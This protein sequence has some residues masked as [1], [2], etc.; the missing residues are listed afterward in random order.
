MN[1]SAAR[2][3]KLAAA[4][5][6]LRDYKKGPALNSSIGLRSDK[7]GSDDAL[8]QLTGSGA[9]SVRSTPRHSITPSSPSVPA[10][11]SSS[12]LHQDSNDFAQRIR[13]L[14]SDNQYLAQRCQ[15]LSEENKKLKAI[16]ET[17][18]PSTEIEEELELLKADIGRLQ[19]DL[20][21]LPGLRD[22][23][24]AMTAEREKLMTNLRQAQEDAGLET[25]RRQFSELEITKEA[26]ESELNELRQS[27]QQLDQI[28]PVHTSNH[29]ETAIELSQVKTERDD[30]ATRLQSLTADLEAKD[31]QV[32]DLRKH[33]EDVTTEFANAQKEVHELRQQ[34]ASK[35]SETQEVANLRSQLEQAQLELGNARKQQSVVMT[36]MRKVLDDMAGKIKVLTNER[37]AATTDAEK[38]RADLEAQTSKCNELQQELSQMHDAE[39]AKKADVND[40]VD[41]MRNLTESNAE[42]KDEVNSLRAR[43]SED[44]VTFKEKDA[45]I[46][47]LQK[48]LSESS[49]AREDISGQIQTLSV[50][51]ADARDEITK[52][53][54]EVTTKDHEIQSISAELNVQL[55]VLEER[56]TNLSETQAQLSLA[57][58]QLSDHA[59]RIS[60]LEGELQR[61]EADFAELQEAL[62]QKESEHQSTIDLLEKKSDFADRLKTQLLAAVDAGRRIESERNELRAQISETSS[63]TAEIAD[64]RTRASALEEEVESLNGQNSHLQTVIESITSEK[65]AVESELSA[66][67]NVEDEKVE[68]EQ[69]MEIGRIKLMECEQRLMNLS[70]ENGEWEE[71]AKEYERERREA[72]RKCEALEQEVEDWRSRYQDL[73]VAV[74]DRKQSSVSLEEQL[75]LCHAEIQELTAFRHEICKM[76]ESL[77]FDHNPEEIGAEIVVTRVYEMKSQVNDARDESQRSKLAV[78]SL[79]V[80]VGELE[81][82]ILELEE[83]LADVQSTQNDS[84]ALRAEMSASVSEVENL[85]GMLEQS[86]LEAER[87]QNEKLSLEEA[88]SQSQRATADFEEK[89]RNAECEVERVKTELIVCVTDKQA[90][91]EQLA[92]VEGQL[93]LLKSQLESVEAERLREQA[94]HQAL[95][96]R[97][98]ELEALQASS[99]N[100]EQQLFAKSAEANELRSLIAEL[101]SQVESLRFQSD[102]SLSEETRLRSE[103]HETRA[104]LEATRSARDEAASVAAQQQTSLAGIQQQ[105]D[106]TIYDN[107]EKDRSIQE[108]YGRLDQQKVELESLIL[109]KDDEV[110]ALQAELV[111]LREKGRLGDNEPLLTEKVQKL[112]ADV[113]TLHRALEEAGER[114]RESEAELTQARE[115]K[116]SLDQSFSGSELSFNSGT[117]SNAEAQ[118]R[119]ELE[120]LVELLEI[121]QHD[122]E[123]ARGEIQ[124]L[125]GRVAGLEGEVYHMRDMLA[126]GD[127][128]RRGMEELIHALEEEAAQRSRGALPHLGFAPGDAEALQLREELTR[129]KQ[130]SKKILALLRST[131]TSTA[132]AQSSPSGTTTPSLVDISTLKQQCQNLVEELLYLRAEVERLRLFRQDLCFQKRYLGLRIAGYERTLKTVVGG[133]QPIAE[134][135]TAVNKW[136]TVAG[137]VR[138]ITRLRVLAKCTNARRHEIAKAFYDQIL[139]ETGLT[140]VGRASSWEQIL[141]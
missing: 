114:L 92:E 107:Q 94:Q 115:K 123:A 91:V 60:T 137:A 24:A 58:T 101:E 110:V 5:K 62:A 21:E 109:K 2:E 89:L 73:E 87:L 4:K 3:A 15:Q 29:S 117:T 41:T 26:L 121:S 105:L 55:S 84:E 52:A 95:T 50:Q 34:T 66:L 45:Q 116:Q 96:A 65:T 10:S 33:L 43:L 11:H 6:R 127:E 80:Q 140:S 72:G 111:E 86:T 100:L 128:E 126:V 46:A 42:L 139:S 141:D 17:Q 78:Q 7:G 99:G 133:T 97:A 57:Q 22:Q 70:T 136:K 124:F 108:L 68:L 113:D 25:L 12:T 77:Q 120:E 88:L 47:A 9:T 130:T 132:F 81:E 20:V 76:A 134:A 37:D 13:S 71:R 14:S 16:C 53:R 135:A 36:N 35:D 44:E 118:L 103:L 32:L 31:Q 112:E 28:P 56:S 67:R 129:V 98:L 106:A 93:T 83:K 51:L 75:A 30:L 82:T 64:L 138:G 19:D 74:Q 8:D 27:S 122:A 131:L 119:R 79:Q 49:E 90:V 61:R 59:S 38:T 1:A 23:L 125:H 104:E 85:K 63:L 39:E 18:P 40:L 54:A 69:S 102:N 48:E